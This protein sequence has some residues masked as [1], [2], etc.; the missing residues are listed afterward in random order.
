LATQTNLHRNCPVCGR[1]DSRKALQKG[2]LALVRCRDCSMIYANP[3]PAELASGAYYDQT[4]A[5][6]YLSPAKLQSDYAP[7]RFERELRLFR[8]WRRE[9]RVLD[10]GCSTG[11]FLY[12]L[13]ERY[14]GEYSLLGS[15]VSGA[16]LDYAES[17]GVE[18]ARGD[19]LANE[20]GGR[21]FDVVTFWAVLEHL[22]EPRCFLQRASKM[23]RPEGL[24]FLLVPNMKSLA[25]RLLGARYRYILPQHLNYFT[26]TTLMRMVKADWSIVEL[27]SMHFNPVVIWQD[28]R[29]GGREISE[30]DRARLLERTTSYKEN[31]FLGPV[32]AVYSLA[33]RALGAL[34]LADN[35]AI[36]L[37]K[38]A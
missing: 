32:K 22:A 23:L 36:V 12:Q 6:Y 13:R 37:R 8:R 26:A 24:C 30:T 3:I 11:A 25:A 19:F 27:R 29:G 1:D 18:V 9:G 7:V 4:A 38:R 14:P 10:V 15:D 21:K 2:G 17:R 28:W 31:P 20:F 16:P 35:L 5:N 33:E 34:R